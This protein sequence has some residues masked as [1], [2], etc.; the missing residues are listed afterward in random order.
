MFLQGQQHN[1]QNDTLQYQDITLNSRQFLISSVALLAMVAATT[2]SATSAWKK[3]G[4]EQLRAMIKNGA[5][6]PHYQTPNSQYTDEPWRPASFYASQDTLQKAPPAI[7]SFCY[8][9]GFH[10][11]AVKPTDT[12]FK[13]W[14][15]PRKREMMMKLNRTNVALNYRGWLLV[16]NDL[17]HTSWNQLSPFPMHRDT[18][19]HALLYVNLSLFAF[20][21]YDKEGNLVRW[22]PA[23]GGRAYC[24][25]LHRSCASATGVYRIYKMGGADC[26]SNEFPLK[27]HGGAP[28]PYCMH[29]FQG[30]AIHASTLMGFVNRS[31]GCVRLFKDDAKWL[32]EH[33]AQVG[34]EV[35]VRQ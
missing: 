11:Q 12:W 19:G 1:Q 32:N 33:F 5:Q 8:L 25:D 31:R 17:N 22:G 15:D 26:K 18:H 24:S 14:P 29:Y 35:M 9:P 10:C 16:P 20:A 21:A 4:E 6:E 28:M 3:A 34:T 30:F 13:L 23:T 7:R 2:V 27:S